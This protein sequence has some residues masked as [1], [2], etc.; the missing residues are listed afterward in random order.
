M[1]GGAMCGTF[2]GILLA[3][4]LVGPLAAAIKIRRDAELHYFTCIKAGL[5]AHLNGY[6]PP[7]SVEFARK[8]LTSDIRPDFFEV[9]KATSE[10]IGRASCRERVCQYV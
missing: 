9:E 4:C 1:I 3:Y 2:L 5:L 8:V 10:K 6:A 7:I